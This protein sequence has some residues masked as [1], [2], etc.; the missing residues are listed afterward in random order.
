MFMLMFLGLVL[1]LMLTTM[2]HAQPAKDR[3]RARALFEEG[4][5]HATQEHWKDAEDR[6]RRAAELY[7]SAAILFNLASVLERQGEYVEALEYLTQMTR[8]KRV[9]KRIARQAKR[10]GEAIAPKI[11]HANIEA[12]NLESDMSL[13]VDGEPYPEAAV[14][15]SMPMNPRVHEVVVE[16]PD[17]RTHRSTFELAPGESRNVVVETPA[18]FAATA[19]N[20]SGMGVDLESSSGQRDREIYPI[21]KKWWFWTALGVAIAGGVTAAVLAT[22]PKEQDPVGG[23]FNPPVIR[24]WSF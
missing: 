2:A 13:Y 12:R 21:H 15:V 6:F 18:S 23:D 22:R 16:A 19:P 9:Q 11:A 7:P 3:A 5:T 8:L 17:G 10:L 20:H 14:G 1:T 24:G 4:V